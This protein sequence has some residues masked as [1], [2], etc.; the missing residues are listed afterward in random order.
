MKK[1]WYKKMAF[2]APVAILAMAIFGFVVMSLW[3]WLVPSLFGGH[4]IGYWQAWGIII[5]SKIL[6]GGIRGRSGPGGRWKH[7]IR[8]RL[9]Q[10]TP[11][12]RE[13][14]LKGMGCRPES[15][16]PGAA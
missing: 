2:I 4:T 15:S 16:A 10:M 12:E 8:E 14:L 11:E 7:R 6:F 1:R 9:E 5:L 13:R 3:N